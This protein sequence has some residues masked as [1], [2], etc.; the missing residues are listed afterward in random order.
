[1][2]KIGIFATFTI[3]LLLCTISFAQVQ[4]PAQSQEG[5]FW[6][7]K[8]R[9]FDYITSRSQTLNGVYEI[10]NLDGKLKIF[11]LKSDK[12][13]E[14]QSSVILALVGRSKNPGYQD[15]KFPLSVG[16]KWNFRYETTII[17]TRE[18]SIRLVEVHVAGTEQVTTPAGTFL[19]Y[20][21]VKDDSG[22]YPCRWVT[23]YFYSPET[24]SIIKS[25]WDSGVGA[26]CR[27]GGG[28]REIELVKFGTLEK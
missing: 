25:F 28:K 10:Q 8:I 19:S 6:Q 11:H 4:A 15:L 22:G 20:K 24:K 21:L 14:V 9:E 1:M 13:E 27:E 5:D 2:K 26:R 18:Y 3:S 17:G 12:K 7:F 23:T 16:Q